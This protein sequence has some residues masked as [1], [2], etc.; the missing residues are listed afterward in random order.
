MEIRNFVQPYGMS[1]IFSDGFCLTNCRSGSRGD[2]GA[3]F[4]SMATEL[5]FNF[6]GDASG[7]FQRTG[8]TWR[9]TVIS[10]FWTSSA[11]F[12]RAAGSG[13]FAS[14]VSGIASANSNGPQEIEA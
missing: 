1:V 11:N 10:G 12:Q 3:G 7:Q 4:Q 9:S 13:V 2:P 8:I 5:T 6:S 14:V